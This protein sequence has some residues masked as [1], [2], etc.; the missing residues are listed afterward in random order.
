MSTVK[1]NDVSIFSTSSIVGKKESEGPLG[2]FFD[3]VVTEKEENSWEEEESRLMKKSIELSIKKASLT[4][5]DINYIFAGD[6]LDQ[7]TGA[8]YGVKDFNIPYIGI[9][10]AC[11]TI[12]LGMGMASMLLNA[13]YGKYSIATASSHFGSAEKQ[14]RS[15]LELGTQRP[16]TTTWT[17]TGAGSV[18]LQKGAAKGPKVTYVTT[19]KVVD[20]GTTD[21]MNM[22]A[23]MAPA[24]VDTII[25]HLKQ[26]G[27]DANYYDMI[28]TGDLGYIGH[29]LVLRLA[30]EQGYKLEN[31]TDCGIL[32]F[33]KEKQDTH[34][35][36]SGCACSAV[37]F[38][39]Y[40]YK[41]MLEKNLKTLLFVPT[42]A[43]MSATSVKQKRPIMGIAHAISIEIV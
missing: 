24:A 16:P 38:A 13:G 19:G 12:G 7:S 14:F 26:T 11:S 37:T 39:G 1:I 40:L 9:F 8:I 32:I 36:G 15:P 23:A 17:V 31:Y 5:G 41:Q 3:E 43:L 10:G 22:G 4:N 2:K 21:P 35:G 27:T 25:N 42:G 33:D 29:E 34:S 20:Y 28:A 18:L 30:S 6:L